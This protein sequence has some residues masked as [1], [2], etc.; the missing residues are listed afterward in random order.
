MREAGIPVVP[1]SPS[2][3]TQE[4]AEKSARE[5][6]Y[7]VMVK[8]SAGG[9]GIGMQLVESR[10]TL[11]KSFNTC[12]TRAGAAFANPA[13]YLEK[14]IPGPRHIEVQVFADSQGNVVHLGERECSIQRRHQ[15]VIEE[16][17]SPLVDPEIRGRIG[18]YAVRAARTIGYVGAG[19]VEFLFDG[20]KNFYFLEMNTRLQVEHPVTEMVTGTDL[21]V[22]QI[23]V[24]AG[25]PLSWSQEDINITGHALECRVYAEDPRTFRP[26]TGE[27]VTLDY[28]SI[29]LPSGE[30]IRVDG[31]IRKGYRVTPYYDPLLAKIIV[32]TGSRQR[33]LD[34]MDEAL[35]RTVIEG[36]KT[37]IPLLRNIVT[38]PEFA[39]GRIST[40]FIGKFF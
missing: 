14:Y 7:P 35:G 12:R 11:E 31:G 21:V 2:L 18:A 8:A 23:R 1:G 16:A 10:D 40:G 20:E 13:V 29:N 5:I 36:V 37:N 28:P 17:P 9:G 38:H 39:A 15:K 19:T 22:E 33:T 30:K 27:I 32:S 34:L 4:E 26:S 3:E 25:F 24:A 6:G